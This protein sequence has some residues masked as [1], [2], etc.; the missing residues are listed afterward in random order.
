ME[1]Y[2]KQ[3]TTSPKVSHRYKTHIG[4]IS[5]LPPCR[6]TLYSFEILSIDGDLFENIERYD[7]LQEAEKRIYELLEPKGNPKTYPE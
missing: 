1:K 7:T 6:A 5:L 2:I 3:F 4:E